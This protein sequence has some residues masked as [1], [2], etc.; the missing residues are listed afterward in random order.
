MVSSFYRPVKSDSHR[1]VFHCARKNRNISE[2][3]ET[4]IW[5]RIFFFFLPPL[6]PL[7]TGNV[8]VQL[9]LILSPP[10]QKKKKL[11]EASFASE[12]Q[13]EDF[14][15]VKH[16]NKQNKLQFT[17]GLI[18]ATKANSYSSALAWPRLRAAHLRNILQ[19]HLRTNRIKSSS[20][21]YELLFSTDVSVCKVW[22]SIIYLYKVCHVYRDILK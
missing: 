10:C 11:Q 3:C 2:F 7:M 22:R 9:F 8:G 5:G 16:Q 12:S 21:D 15:C 1:S 14:F 18:F 19:F 20:D 6:P 4:I 13:L 17:D